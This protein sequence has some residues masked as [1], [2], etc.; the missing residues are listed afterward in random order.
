MPANEIVLSQDENPQIAMYEAP[1]L[2]DHGPVE[3]I[4]GVT[5]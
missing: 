5:G 1:Q 4:T 2:I 3:E